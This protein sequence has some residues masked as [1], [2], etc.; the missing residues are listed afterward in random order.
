VLEVTPDYFIFLTK[1]M[2]FVL[3]TK[4]RIVYRLTLIV[5]E[6]LF[7]RKRLKWKAGITFTEKA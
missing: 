5:M 3:F 4:I 6:I 2:L 1:V 7:Q